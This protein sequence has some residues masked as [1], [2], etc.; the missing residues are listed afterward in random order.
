MGVL[1]LARVSG[2]LSGRRLREGGEVVFGQLRLG[3]GD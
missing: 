3:L 1:G 2:P